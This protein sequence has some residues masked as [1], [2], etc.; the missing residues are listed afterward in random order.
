MDSRIEKLA[1]TII[2]YSCDVQEGS[3][4]T[5]DV[6]G[7]TPKPL[8]K[9][10]VRYIYDNKA[11]P[12]VIVK[13][14]SIVREQLLG[15]TEESA[16]NWAKH[17]LYRLQDTDVYILIES[18]ENQYE[19]SDIPKDKMS[20]YG[21]NYLRIINSYIL[22]NTRWIT[23]RYPNSA[24]AQ[25]SN[26]SLDAFK[27]FYFSVCNLDYSKLSKAMD[28][29]VDIMSN[30]DEVHITGN[31]CDLTFSIKD[32]PICKC[33]G[34]INL[35]D[36]EVYTAPIRDS[37]NGIVR[38]NAPSIYQGVCFEDIMLKLKDGRIVDATSSNTEKMHDILDTDEG[39][40]YIGEFALGLNP[41]IKKPT[42]DILFDEKIGGSFHLTPG[43]SYENAFNGNCSS[44]HWDMVCIQTEEYGGGE[45]YFDGKLI[46]KNG[47][48]LPK[49]LA[50]LNNK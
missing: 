43:Y 18:L 39:S 23:L 27:D 33:D 17:D 15:I 31:G 10:L 42:K 46:R 14:A 38:F 50:Y 29:L 7:D 4:V 47:L 12:T 24:I 36:G 25:L 45:I 6:M 9:S 2:N 16:T 37:I 13:D 20:I 3:L 11:I 34:L 40:R 41:L 35:P 44:I 26:M 19:L 21:E 5:I 1:S 22:S 49:E 30:T 28:K 8:V 48:F 32:M